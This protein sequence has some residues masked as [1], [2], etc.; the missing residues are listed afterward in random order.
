MQK[1]AR[2]GATGGAAPRS[3]TVPTRHGK[4]ESPSSQPL[5]QATQI[6][7]DGGLLLPRECNRAASR[8]GVTATPRIQPSGRGRADDCIALTMRKPNHA[9]L[10]A[11]VA[12]LL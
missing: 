9:R 6:A 3:S 1:P 12:L 8:H 2:P 5:S 7:V 10:T 4:Q 11:A